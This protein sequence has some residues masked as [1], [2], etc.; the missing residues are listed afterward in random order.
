MVSSFAF[1]RECERERERERERKSRIA[2]EN[3]RGDT[4]TIKSCEQSQNEN[5]NEITKVKTKH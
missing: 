2:K 4:N 1:K 5:N 3:K